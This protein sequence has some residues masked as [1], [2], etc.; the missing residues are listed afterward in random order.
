MQLEHVDSQQLPVN[1]SLMHLPIRQNL[2]KTSLKYSKKHTFNTY[3]LS[4]SNIKVPKI[5]SFPLFHVSAVKTANEISCVLFDYNR[6]WTKVTER[7][8]PNLLNP[9]NNIMFL[10]FIILKLYTSILDDDDDPLMYHWPSL[11]WIIHIC[12]T[13]KINDK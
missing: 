6:I 7:Q 9:K 12:I 3:N 5:N 4:T 1:R 13:L 8:I 2:S 10:V 11:T